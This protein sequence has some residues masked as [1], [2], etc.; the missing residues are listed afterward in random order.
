LIDRKRE[1]MLFDE[2]PEK[3]EGWFATPQGALVR[4]Y[5]G[6]LLLDLLKPRP[7]EFILDAGCGT[8]VFTFD[9]LSR[10][11]GVIGLDISL[12]MLRRAGRK[13]GR[14]A[15]PMVLGDMLHLPFPEESFDRVMSVTALE[16]IEDAQG[17]FEE[18]FRVTKRG[19]GIVVATLNSLSP[20]AARRK[21]K[22]KEGQ[23]IFEKAIFRSPD[24]LRSLASIE[25]VIRTAIHFQKE[26]PPAMAD[27][28]E[29]EG[30]RRR[31]DTGAFVAGCW[32]KT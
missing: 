21:K 22:A 8:G 2:W 17:A 5:E 15:L 9:V 23:S 30:R 20:W 28:I 31:L 32:K 10:E 4:K 29:R 14:F 3:Y 27:E 18:L 12:P 24:E 7:G 11:T 13:A 1:S 19:G 16:F 6:E 26:D 25:G